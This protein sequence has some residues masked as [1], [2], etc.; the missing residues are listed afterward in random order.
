[1]STNGRQCAA[2][3]ERFWKYSEED[4]DVAWCEVGEERVVSA[5][6]LWSGSQTT[7]RRSRFVEDDDEDSD[8]EPPSMMDVSRAVKSFNNGPS[9]PR[10]SGAQRGGVITDLRNSGALYDSS[11][12][13]LPGC[14]L[15]PQ[16]L[17]PWFRVVDS[18]VYALDVYTVTQ[19]ASAS[20]ECFIN[21]QCDT[22]VYTDAASF[23]LQVPLH[24]LV[25]VRMGWSQERGA[26]LFRTGVHHMERPAQRLKGF[27]SSSVAP[28]DNM[29]SF[30][31]SQSFH[32]MTEGGGGGG[33]GEAHLSS[34]MF[35]STSEVGYKGT[36]KRL[37]DSIG[38]VALQLRLS[39][40]N[41]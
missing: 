29:G 8:S 35:G 16:L 38:T 15:M 26:D 18:A 39:S 25:C 34:S 11:P 41:P 12:E 3:E 23:A 27:R 36:P 30:G 19:A 33:G 13:L 40:K 14:A 9:S 37:G 24:R 6:D 20:H 31:A 5:C 32:S 4:L 7:Q 21:V 10:R 28:P 2:A 1:M 17:T 22:P